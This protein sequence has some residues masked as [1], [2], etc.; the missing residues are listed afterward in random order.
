MIMIILILNISMTIIIIYLSPDVVDVSVART[1]RHFRHLENIFFVLE[2]IRVVKK[3][4]S[5][6]I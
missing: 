1:P 3:I 5:P 6:S 2:N 4:S